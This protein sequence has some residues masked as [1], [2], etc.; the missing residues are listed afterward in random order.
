VMPVKSGEIRGIG[1]IPLVDYGAAYTKR[2]YQPVGKSM[3]A[4]VVLAE[5][6]GAVHT[7]GL[8]RFIINDGNAVGPCSAVAELVLCFERQ[9][10]LAEVAVIEVPVPLV[11]VVTAQEHAQLTFGAGYAEV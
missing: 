5:E 3:E 7:A 9:R 1:F 11:R 2:L 4:L 6:I 10:Q 8:I